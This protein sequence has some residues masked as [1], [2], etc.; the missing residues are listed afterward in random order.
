MHGGAE[1]PQ[2]L[3]EAIAPAP[4][5]RCNTR[6]VT[7]LH[8]P[9]VLH[10]R[11]LVAQL[12]CVVHGSSAVVVENR[13]NVE[14]RQRL[15]FARDGEN[16]TGAVGVNAFRTTSSGAETTLEQVVIDDRDGVIGLEVD[17]TPCRATSCVDVDVRRCGIRHEE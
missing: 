3:R 7:R 9:F 12:S 15:V 10:H 6:L 16:A 5:D 17:P 1:A 8:G 13:G 11:Q 4:H 14:E 2:R